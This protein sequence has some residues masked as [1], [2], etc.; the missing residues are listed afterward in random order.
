[1]KNTQL[2]H[3]TAISLL[4]LSPAYASVDLIAIGS[5][6]GSYED[7]AS[8]TAAPLENGLPGNRLG[9]IGSGLAYA[10]GNTFLALPDRGPKCEALQQ[11]CRRHGLLYPALSYVHAESRA[12]RHGIAV[13]VHADTDVAQ[14]DLAVEPVAARVWLWRRAR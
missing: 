8:A 5:I 6:S 9:G 7:L 1:M 11:S 12:Q 10:G 3:G 13:A 2:I 14:D 4:L